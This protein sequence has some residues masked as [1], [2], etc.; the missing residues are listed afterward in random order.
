[1]FDIDKLIEEERKTRKAVELLKASENYSEFF[2][3]IESIP[4][5]HRNDV[6]DINRWDYAES[7][8][9]FNSLAADFIWQAT[10]CLGKAKSCLS[11][12]D[13]FYYSQVKMWEEFRNGCLKQKD[14]EQREAWKG[15]YANPECLKFFE[16][17]EKAHGITDSIYANAK[18]K[19]KGEK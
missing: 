4:I 19:T 14:P 15:L 3:K 16:D 5:S 17:Y 9:R 8:N 2:N 6:M 18:D 7:S 13:S 11:A 12:V 10:D 1:M